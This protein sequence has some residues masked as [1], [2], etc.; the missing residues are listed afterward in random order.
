LTIETARLVLRPME[1]ADAE[2][3]HAVYSDPT[4]FEFIAAAPPPIAY[5]TSNS[6]FRRL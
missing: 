5:P 4:T 2:E 6:R 1:A 3:L